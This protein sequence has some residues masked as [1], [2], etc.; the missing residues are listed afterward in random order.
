MMSTKDQ[1]P[2]QNIAVNSEQNNSPTLDDN[3]SEKNHPNDRN[4]HK[5]VKKG[6]DSFE[7]EHRVSSDYQI[8]AKNNTTR[9]FNNS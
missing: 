3:T 8:R 6:D 7:C 9:C 2:N 1:D 4:I 5:R